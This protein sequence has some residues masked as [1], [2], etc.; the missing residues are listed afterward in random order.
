M[1]YDLI[2]VDAEGP[3]SVVTL[4]QSDVMNAWTWQMHVE[5]RHAFAAL[6]DDD[7]VRAIVLT[8]AG[9]DFCAG[10]AL[11]PSG[12][13]FDG[14]QPGP[15]SFE[16]RYPGPKKDAHELATPVIAAVNGAAVGVGLTLA[17]GCDI[18]IVADDAKLGAVFN[19][20]GVIPDGDLLWS[21]PRL[22]GYARA[23]DLL[24]TGRIFT[25][26]E[27]AALGLASRAVPREVVLATALEVAHDLAAN[28]A[29]V[30]AAVTKRL[31]Q[32]FLEEHD[33]AAATQLQ[34]SLFSWAGTQPDAKEGVVAF[35]QKRRPRWTMSKTSDLPDSAR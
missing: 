26:H 21:L 20:R 31:A 19:R 9:R 4:N 33:R 30:S 22:I 23:I 1:T 15:S 25:G 7:G 35:L 10:A 2:A 32:R 16:N 6:D 8:G 3:V 12:A 34:R 5:L 11:V 13:T 18:R 14:T 29:P 17:L 28:V 27:A 24:L